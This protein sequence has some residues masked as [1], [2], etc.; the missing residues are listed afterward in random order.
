MIQIAN[1]IERYNKIILD[2]LKEAG[3]KTWIAGGAVR[4][5]FMGVP[6]KTD[7]DLFF[8]DLK[9]YEK[10]AT[11]F[12]AKEAVIKWESDNGMKVKYIYRSHVCG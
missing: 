2:E 8:P 4:D 6:I 9:E 3:I 5:Y 11:Y 1:T 12:K 7:I 10:T